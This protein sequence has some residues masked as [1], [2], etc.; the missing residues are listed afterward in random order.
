MAAGA[1][2]KYKEHATE[3]QA[4][5]IYHGRLVFVFIR[6]NGPARIRGFVFC[7]NLPAVAPFPDWIE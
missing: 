2:R 3:L 7:V 5:T 4:G 6:Y 1:R